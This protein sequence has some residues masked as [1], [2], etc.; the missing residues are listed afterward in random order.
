MTLWQPQRRSVLKG[1]LAAY[2]LSAA[3]AAFAKMF[4]YPRAFAGPM[5]GAPGPNHF[6][7]WVKT[8]G[9][10]PVQ[11]EYST[12]PTFATV[13][14]GTSAMALR[15]NHYCVT[16]RAEGLTA[17]DALLLPAAVRRRP[18]PLSAASVPHDDSARWTI[19]LHGRLRILL[20]DPV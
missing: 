17:G 12:E 3:P 11:L 5:V 13:M 9:A 10:F 14:K 16:V 8:T 7:V 15:E 4:G 19:R 1:G 2:L 18:R 20:P 6:T